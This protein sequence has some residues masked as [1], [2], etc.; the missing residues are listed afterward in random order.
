MDKIAQKAISSRDWYNF[1]APMANLFPDLHP[2]GR[3]ATDALLAMCSL[4]ESDR[5][6]DVGCGSGNTACRIAQEYGCQV[7]GI[8]RSEVMIAQAE[9]RAGALGVADRITFQITDIFRTPFEDDTFDVALFQSVLVPLPG[10]PAQA[11]AEIIRV[12]RLGGRIGANE[13]TVVPEAPPEFHELMEKH[14]GIYHI[15]TP[16]TLRALFEDAGLRVAAMEE[17]ESGGI[18]ETSKMSLRNLLSFMVRVY[19]RILIRLIRDPRLREVS[20]IDD[21]LTKLGKQYIGYT[22]IVGQ[23]AE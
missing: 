20:Q 17:T 21:R 10:D 18:P 14:P 12:V 1:V 4:K 15:F 11:L 7:V 23:K 3:A 19:P 2:G 5:V 9:K 8:D 16:K 13:G 6:L 22:L